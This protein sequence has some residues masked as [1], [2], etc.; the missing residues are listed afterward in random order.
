MNDRSLV[1]VMTQGIGAHSFSF[2]FLRLRLRVAFGSG[3]A[4]AISFQHAIERGRAPAMPGGDI[5]LGGFGL[6]HGTPA[7]HTLTQAQLDQH[8][9]SRKRRGRKLPVSDESPRKD[10][11]VAVHLTRSQVNAVRSAFKAGITP[12]RIARE[13]GISQSDVRNAL[14]SDERKR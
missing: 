1:L 5:S 14:A 4:P 3:R 11:A 9:R 6:A 13:F 7:A 10:R 2:A 8:S 12:S